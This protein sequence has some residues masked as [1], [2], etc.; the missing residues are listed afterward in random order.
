[1]SKSSLL[2]QAESAYSAVLRMARLNW[3]RQYLQM[4]MMWYNI[5]NI[6]KLKK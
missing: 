2:W 5:G 3:L 1:M 6:N 4:V